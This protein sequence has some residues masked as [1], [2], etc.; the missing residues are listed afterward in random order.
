MPIVSSYADVIRDWELLLKAVQDNIARLPDIDRYAVLLYQSGVDP[1]SGEGTH[2][3]LGLP[4][5]GW[6][7]MMDMPCPTC[8][9]T[10]AFANA[11]HGRFWQSFRAQPMGFLLALA[12]AMTLLV[13]MHTLITGSRLPRAFLRL[14][15]VRSGWVLAVLIVAAWGYKIASHK[16]W[17]G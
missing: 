14:W 1:L 11:A 7:T 17:L 9:M 3:Q 2:E 4:K 5:C 13:C 8:G 6:I 10:T 16:G 12:T 15:G